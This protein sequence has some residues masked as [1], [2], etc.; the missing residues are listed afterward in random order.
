[1]AGSWF[2]LR[3]AGGGRRGRG[4]PPLPRR[5]R[6]VLT[7]TLVAATLTVIAAPPA[8]AATLAH[9]IQLDCGYSSSENTFRPVATVRRDGSTEPDFRVSVAMRL[10]DGATQLASL[11]TGLLG[12]GA[13]G[14]VNVPVGETRQLRPE[15]GAEFGDGG[16]GGG[17]LLREHDYVVQT[18]LFDFD[19]SSSSSEPADW[20]CSTSSEGDS[21]PPTVAVNTPSSNAVFSLNSSVQADFGCE[22]ESDGSGLLSCTGT[23]SSGSFLDTST[24]CGHS[25]TVDAVD[26]AGN[27]TVVTR[28]YMVVD[29]TGDDDDRDGLP[30][31]WEENG[32][33]ENCDGTIDL[34]LDQAPFNADP[35]RPDLFVEIDRMSGV[36]VDSGAIDDVESA[37]AAHGVVLHAMPGE[38]VP[39]IDPIDFGGSGPDSFDQIKLGSPD[40]NCDG[41]FGSVEDRDS[42]NCGNVLAAKRLVFRYAIYGYNHLQQPGSSGIAEGIPGDDFMVTLGGWTDQDID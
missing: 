24:T 20:P 34:P 36:V 10:F 21:T 1:M 11:G 18:S 4:S 33:D 35:D 40:A 31:D 6:L 39:V 27:H 41:F 29:D 30:N 37:F 26:N 25:F 13:N 8:Q 19:D 15:A 2:E 7:I 32:I 16:F 3:P 9:V 17:S 28:S 14:T 23:L 5:F 42:G 12:S 22:D 38:L